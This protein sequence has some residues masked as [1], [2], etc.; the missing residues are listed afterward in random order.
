MEAMFFQTGCRLH[1]QVG[2]LNLL[3]KFKIHDMRSKNDYVL[4][5]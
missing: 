4:Y 2:E 3:T 5:F 1:I